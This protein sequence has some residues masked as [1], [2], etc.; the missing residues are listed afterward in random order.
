VSDDRQ[1]I[2]TP[3]APKP[4]GPY[5]Q[6]VMAGGFLF[7]A[8]QVGL[9]PATGKLIGPDAATQ[10]RQALDNL[11]AILAGAQMS[12]R[13]VVKTSIFLASM[14]DFAAVNAVYAERFEGAPPAR[15]TVAVAGLPVGARVEIEMIARHR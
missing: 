3:R 2:N 1:V 13:D 10:A 11:E 5:S 15:S 6:G 7:T 14:D 12:M 9:S 8:G 4:V